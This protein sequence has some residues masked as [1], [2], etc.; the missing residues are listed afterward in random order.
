MITFFLKLRKFLDV[1]M[2]VTVGEWD[3]ESLTIR[4]DDTGG[5]SKLVQ[6]QQSSYLGDNIIL[7]LNEAHCLKQTSKRF[8]S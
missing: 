7:V 5:Q 2:E 8:R 1:W 6:L 4:T 3:T